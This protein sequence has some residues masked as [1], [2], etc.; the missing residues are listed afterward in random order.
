MTRFYQPDLTLDFDSPFIR[1]G[2]DKL[3]RR[4]H[5]EFRVAVADYLFPMSQKY[6]ARALRNRSLR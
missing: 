5:C 4:S 1:D 6:C 2:D 3:I